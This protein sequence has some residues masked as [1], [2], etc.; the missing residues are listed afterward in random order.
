MPN[1]NEYVVGTNPLNPD[2][3]YDGIPDGIE[4]ANRNGWVDGD[5]RLDFVATSWG[6]NTPMQADSARPL[7]MLH[8]PVGARGEEE[9]AREKTASLAAMQRRVLL[10]DL[11]PQGNAT[12]GC[13]V[14]KRTLERRIQAV[15][16]FGLARA[17]Q[18]QVAEFH[19]AVAA[20]RHRHLR[21]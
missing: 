12:M 10:I 2:S 7:V 5:G 17:C 13:G 18:H 8:G 14:D 19:V 9:M 11:D 4:D 3:D 20:H 6:R 1:W 21:N 16:Q 15:Q